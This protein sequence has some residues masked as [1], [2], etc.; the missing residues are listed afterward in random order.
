M[1]QSL[2]ALLLLAVI[3]SPVWLWILGL[4]FDQ[5]W[6]MMPIAWCLMMVFKLFGYNT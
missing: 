2:L 3:T 4:I 6:M 1:R 5:E